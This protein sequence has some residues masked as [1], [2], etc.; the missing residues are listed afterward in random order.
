[1]STSPVLVE[2][3]NRIATITLNRPQALNAYNYEMHDALLAALD[4]V[5]A[6]D[7]VR[8]VVLTGTGRGFCAGPRVERSGGRKSRTLRSRLRKSS[9]PRLL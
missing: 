3:T 7:D 2:T 1:M 8:A 5:D 4:T 6:D 9:K